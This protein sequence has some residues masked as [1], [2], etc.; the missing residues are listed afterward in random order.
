MHKLFIILLLICLVFGCKES[1]KERYF[2]VHYSL[3]EKNGP[4]SNTG[5]LWFALDSFPSK[6][7][8]DSYVYGVA[9]KER[10][11]YDPVE[12]T[13]I[14]EFKSEEDFKAFARNYRGNTNFDSTR[15]HNSCCCETLTFLEVDSSGNV[16][17]K[18]KN[19]QP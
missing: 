4:E 16:I 9:N 10:E 15:Q 12:I 13:F 3:S 8:I 5:D 14:F 17:N 2:Y 6:K 19:K 18:A 11:C 7:Y 1:R